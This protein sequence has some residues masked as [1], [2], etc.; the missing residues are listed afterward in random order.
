MKTGNSSK[1][2]K[3]GQTPSGAPSRKRS[4]GSGSRSRQASAGAG[5]AA[6]VAEISDAQIAERAKAIWQSRG[7]PAGCDEQN[8]YEAR[9]QLEAEATSGK[10]DRGGPT[11]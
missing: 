10:A 8:W 11:A 4:A 3:A 9:A 6:G 5:S 2:N 1:K 7:C